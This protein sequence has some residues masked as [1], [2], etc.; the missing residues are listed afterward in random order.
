[1]VRGGDLAYFPNFAKE[2]NPDYHINRTG[3][4]E[5]VADLL[6]KTLKSLGEM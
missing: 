2:V 1:M 5:A 3:V 6:L 4:S